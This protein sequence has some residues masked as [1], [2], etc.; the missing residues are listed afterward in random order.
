MSLH[1][2]WSTVCPLINHAGGI[3]EM[4][5]FQELLR[6]MGN[7]EAMLDFPRAVNLCHL[8]MSVES[9]PGDVVEFGCYKGHTAALM[10]AITGK[11]IR[12]YDSFEGLPE[13]GPEDEGRRSDF[14]KGYLKADA[15]EVGDVM[16]IDTVRYPTPIVVVGWFKDLKDYQLPDKIAF[17]HIDADLFQSTWDALMFV[18]PRMFPGGVI[19]VDDYNNH[20]LPGVSLAVNKWLYTAN[21]NFTLESQPLQAVI[22]L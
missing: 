13:P 22:W 5:S 17:A 8:L 7:T 2:V 6:L 21:R 3:L 20:D 15:H 4:K 14:Q 11:Q 9:V 16:L 10:A 19:V 12:L 1:G 18:V